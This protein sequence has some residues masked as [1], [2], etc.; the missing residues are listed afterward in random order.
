VASIL[1]TAATAQLLGVTLKCP[2]LLEANDI[3]RWCTVWALLERGSYD[4]TE[5]PWRNRTQ[6]RVLRSNK[7]EAPDSDAGLLRRVEYA[8]APAHW[9]TGEAEDRFF[10][11]KPPLLP[12]LIAGVLYPARRLAGVPLDAVFEEPRWPE[13]NVEKEVPGQPGKFEYTTERDRPP[14][15]WPYYVYYFKP[16]LLL[17]NVLP[18]LCFLIGYARY[19]DRA[20]RNDF[21]WFLSLTAGAWGTYLFAFSQTLNNHTVA[22]AS[23]AFASLSL[24]RLFDREPASYRSAFF[25]GF[26]SALA[27]ANEIPAALLG[28]LA[29]FLVLGRSP[30]LAVTAFVPAAVIP[31]FAFFATQL[32]AFGQFRP[33]YEEF[34]TQS[35]EYAGSYWNTPLEFDWFN[36]NPEHPA[37][38]LWH[39]TIGHHG[40][41]SLTPLLFFAAWGAAR[42]LFVGTA[43]QKRI[44]GLALVL[45]IGMLAFYA[46][47]PKARNY[48]GSTQG[49]RWLFWLI[50][51]WLFCLPAG[52]EAGQTRRVY[53]WLVLLALGVSVMS[54]GF[55]LRTPWSHPWMLEVLERLGLYHLWR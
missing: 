51:F 9:K 17:L 38:Y 37:V 36:R 55:A 24:V 13:R 25:A 35:Y 27:A 28:I 32:A 34:G 50:P 49:L 41:F 30:R 19:L 53:R 1:I 39:M 4:I 5:C 44:A 2:S 22:A 21:A 46:W 29:F 48:G 18:Y 10:S 3:S 43:G 20:A 8:L 40:I 12:S 26:W 14:V 45:S 31:L 11:S 16:V 15:K 7:L 23:A 52:V 42:L 54:V 47:N 6:D 33:V